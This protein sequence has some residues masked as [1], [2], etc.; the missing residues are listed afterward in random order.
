MLTLIFLLLLSILIPIAITL[1]SQL[2]RYSKEFNDVAQKNYESSEETFE[3]P[4]ISLIKEYLPYFSFF[5][6][7]EIPITLLIVWSLYPSNFNTILL[8]FMP[9]ISLIFIYIAYIALIKW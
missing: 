9:L 8:L 7:L 6:V 3:G 5:L 2:I 1:F 4:S